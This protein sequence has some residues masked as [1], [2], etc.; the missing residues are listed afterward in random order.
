MNNRKQYQR[1]K[2][3]YVFAAQQYIKSNEEKGMTDKIWGH[4]VLLVVYG[5]VLKCELSQTQHHILTIVN[6]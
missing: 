4:E 2:N 3:C 1:H 6:E 5:S